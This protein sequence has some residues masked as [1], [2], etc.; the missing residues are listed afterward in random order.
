MQVDLKGS[1]FVITGK[2]TKMTRYE[3]ES[4]IQKVG[5]KT[6]KSVTKKT[7]YLIVGERPSSKYTKAKN[8]GIPILTE[9]DFKALIAGKTV[10]VEEVGAAGDRSVDELLGEVRGAM[11]GPPTSKM[12][13]ELVGLLDACR[14]E[15]VGVLTEYIDSYIAR[16]TAE[17]MAK[18]VGSSVH[19]EEED[20]RR[21]WYYYYYRRGVQGELRVAPQDWVGQMQQG[22]DSPKFKIVRALELT[23]SKMTSTAVT[24][25]INH[26]A[27]EHL[28]TLELPERLAPSKTLIKTLCNHP[29]ISHL[30]IG[31]VD[32]KTAPGF[33]E[34]GKEQGLLTIL[35]LTNL[36]PAYKLRTEA[37]ICAFLKVPYFSTVASLYLAGGRHYDNYI[38][39]QM[40]NHNVLPNVDHIHCGHGYS[41]PQFF[42]TVLASSW[43]TKKLKRLGAKELFFHK[44]RERHWAEMFDTS[45]GGQLE[46]LDLSGTVAAWNVEKGDQ[47]IAAMFKTYLPEANLLESVDTLILGKW[48]TDELVE[49]L[50]ETHPELTVS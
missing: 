8:M 23:D 45:F 4:A 24:K 1:I 35:D 49:K 39:N 36:D 38:L 3:A 29:T 40:T 16:W 9:D 33:E 21:H 18:Q 46:V 6:G 27:L 34:Y 25:V 43:A 11:Q 47:K 37:E 48:K 14:A 17:S 2:L 13:H 30:K 5:G 32:E 22:V 31:K 50:A 7:S 19:I 41:S 12:W 10:E 26:P 28:E 44:E 20:H 42:A 15:D